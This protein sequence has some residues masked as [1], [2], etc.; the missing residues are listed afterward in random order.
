MEPWPD[1]AGIRCLP[2]VVQRERQPPQPRRLVM[3]PG[4]H[5]WGGSSDQLWAPRP[6]VGD[7]LGGPGLGSGRNQQEQP[8]RWA[9]LRAGLGEAG[10]GRL[11]STPHPHPELPVMGAACTSSWGRVGSSWSTVEPP[12]SENGILHVSTGVCVVW[13]VT[14][15]RKVRQGPWGRVR[16]LGLMLRVVWVFVL[17]S[18]VLTLQGFPSGLVVKNSA[19]QTWV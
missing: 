2:G 1:P 3:V 16:G 14:K 11:A 18:V 6:A 10:R 13:A 12:T 9:A 4:R 19:I 8:Q 5:P 15:D 7:A 17:V